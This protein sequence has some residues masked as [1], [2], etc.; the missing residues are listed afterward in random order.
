[1]FM[2]SPLRQRN[3]DKID[4]HHGQFIEHCAAQPQIQQHAMV[5]CHNMNKR[6]EFYPPTMADCRENGDQPPS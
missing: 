6:E 3:E 5:D 1:M 4:H 2:H